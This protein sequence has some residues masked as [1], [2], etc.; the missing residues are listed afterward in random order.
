MLANCFAFLCMKSFII[1][2]CLLASFAIASFLAK[3]SGAA[4]CENEK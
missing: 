4:A 3:A 1:S 2:N